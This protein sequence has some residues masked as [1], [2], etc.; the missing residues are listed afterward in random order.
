MQILVPETVGY[1]LLLR[2]EEMSPLSQGTCKWKAMLP[3]TKA[4]GPYTIT[5]SSKKHG[6]AS[7]QD[8]LF[9]DVWICGGQSNMVF[10]VPQVRNFTII[11]YKSC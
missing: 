6:N 9:G 1:P 2:V 7:L 3:A 8:V 5:A 10:T 11:L 4:G